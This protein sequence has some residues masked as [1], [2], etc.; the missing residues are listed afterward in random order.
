[1]LESLSLMFFAVLN[2]FKVN[3]KVKIAVSKIEIKLIY[4]IS[5]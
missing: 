4:E 2:I 1:M 5:L 3:T